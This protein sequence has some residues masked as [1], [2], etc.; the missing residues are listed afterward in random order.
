MTVYSGQGADSSA[1]IKQL[2]Q[3]TLLC[4]H[5]SFE[6]IP[7]ASAQVCSTNH[8]YTSLVCGGLGMDRKKYLLVGLLVLIATGTE[9]ATGQ[10]KSVSNPKAA[11]VEEALSAFLT[12]FDNLDWPAFRASFSETATIFHPAPP[13]I[14]RIDSPEQFEKAWLAVFERIKRTSGRTSPPYM[15]LKPLDLRVEKLSEEV[16]LVTFHLVDGRL[17]NRRTLVFKHEMNGWKIVHIHASNIAA[18]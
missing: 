9:S 13:N 17:V 15:S 7:R 1:V 2:T 3:P 12:A 8:G 18:P 6:P 11:S 4:N 5:V 14:R 16:A 10:E